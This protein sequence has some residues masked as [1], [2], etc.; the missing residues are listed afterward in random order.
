VVEW[1]VNKDGRIG[2]VTMTCHDLLSHF[3]THG[4]FSSDF[5]LEFFKLE[6]ARI[7]IILKG[8]VIKVELEF[9][10]FTSEE[11]KDQIPARTLCNTGPVLVMI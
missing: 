2:A 6:E 11:L 4:V 3:D 9:F 5:S 10:K 7:K 1:P 8:N